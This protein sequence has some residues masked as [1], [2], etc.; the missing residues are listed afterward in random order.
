MDRHDPNELGADI[1]RADDVGKGRKH[2]RLLIFIDLWRLFLSR[3]LQNTLG[4]PD[5]IG[6]SI[7]ILVYGQ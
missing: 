3:P 6:G 4:P 1:F 2:C 5:M 7:L